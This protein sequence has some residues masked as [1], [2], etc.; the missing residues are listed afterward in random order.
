MER[1]RKPRCNVLDITNK[2]NDIKVL[3]V[4][5]HDCGSGAANSSLRIF[6]AVKSVGIQAEMLVQWKL[7]AEDYVTSCNSRFLSKQFTRLRYRL[8]RHRVR[9]I[10]DE[11]HTFFSYGNTSPKDT[12]DYINGSNADIVH[13]HWINAGFLSIQ[14]I[15]KINK[16]IVWSL[17]DMWPFTGGCHYAADCEAYASHCGNCPVLRAPA[18]RDASNSIALSKQEHFPDSIWLVGSSNWITNKAKKSPLFA[19]SRTICIPTPVD[20]PMDRIDRDSARKALSL[21]LNKRLILFGAQNVADSRKGFE[22]LLSALKLIGDTQTELVLFG[23]DRNIQLSEIPIKNHSL[24]L[25]T[26]PDTL[27]QLYVAADVLVVPSIQENL[28]NIIL[29]GLSHRCP[30]VA[31]DI[32]GNSDM[33]EHRVN[34]SLIA[35]PVNCAIP[36][37]NEIKRWLSAN[38]LQRSTVKLGQQFTPESVGHAYRS[39]YDKILN[40]NAPLP[41]IQ[42]GKQGSQ[43]V[44]KPYRI[45]D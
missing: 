35:S 39:L 3:F 21:P 25:L 23:R 22:Y 27:K 32:G 7:S 37:H 17:H 8:E 42:K 43:R 41:T 2:S 33:I 38:E 12:I 11:Y 29:E 45:I 9:Q 44:K 31:F 15:G 6:Q 13:L 1:A 5:T 28:S 16:P 34:G 40:Q 4:S 10:Q 24:G 26:D 20:A 19:T 18:P 30:V 14:D 36:M